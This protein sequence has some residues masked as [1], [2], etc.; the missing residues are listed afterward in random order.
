LRWRCAWG[1]AQIRP[2]V[3]FT[4]FPAV[5]LATMFGGYRIGLL[6][7]VAAGRSASPSIFGDARAD[8]RASCCW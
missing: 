1:R 5:V 4:Y 8:P 2:D 3:F 7:A 6:T